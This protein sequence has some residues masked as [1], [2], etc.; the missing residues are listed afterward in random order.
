MQVYDDLFSEEGSEVYV[1]PISLYFKEFENEEISFA[2]CMLAA[3]QRPHQ[4][5]NGSFSGDVY[6]SMKPIPKKVPRPSIS[7][8]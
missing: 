2:D 3:Q 7:S 8:W 4:T 1:K 5:E 6:L